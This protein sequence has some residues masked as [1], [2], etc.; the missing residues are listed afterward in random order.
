MIALYILNILLIPVLA[1]AAPIY[2]TRYFRL[3]WINL[4]IIPVIVNLPVG[5]LTTLSGPAVFLADGLF[6]PYFQY[7]LFVSNVYSLL[8][9]LTMIWIVRLLVRHP[10]A[11]R[12]IERAARQ[13][14]S[15]R[16]ERMRAAGWLFLGLFVVSFV[17]LA[18][19]TYGLVNW[20]LSPRT[21]Y[22]LYR[23][24]AG[25]WYAFAITFLSVS[26]VLA[27]V[28]ARSTYTVIAQAP[29]YL[30][31]TYL[32]GSKGFIIDFTAY[33]VI[34]L[35]IRQFRYFK[36]F[37]LVVLVASTALVAYNLAS[38]VGGYGLEEIASYSDYFVN[39][40][41]YYERYLDG[42]LPLYHGEI[43][44]SSFWGLV[45]RALYPN[46]PYVY[47]VIKVIDVFYPGAAEASGTPAFA[48]VDYFADFGWLG[49]FFNGIVN[50]ANVMNAFLYALVLP[51]LAAFN[52]RNRIAHSS[53]LTYAFLLLVGPAFLFFFGFPLNIVLFYAIVKTIDVTNRL[54]VVE[55]TRAPQAA[56][57]GSQ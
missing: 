32:L 51:R 52:I 29:I 17:L 50:P 22:Q 18:Q 13:G 4:L 28:Y 49:V 8:G 20:I 40:A 3:G 56:A 25:Q 33:L 38:A 16:P 53:V 42:S 23:T 15:V 57:N 37:A 19:P 21:G 43:A 47:G 12:F 46:K 10:R 2:F 24:G 6:N 41:K 11:S 39:A 9:I 55:S 5:L 36:P 45:P 26:M 27:T 31:G 34:I 35:A 54:H 30:F 7:A 44:F 14:V 48:T 1:L